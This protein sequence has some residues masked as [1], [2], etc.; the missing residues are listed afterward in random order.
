MDFLFWL[1]VQFIIFL[2]VAFLLYKFGE[3]VAPPLTDVGNKLRSYACGD[4]THYP[5]LSKIEANFHLF[6]IAVFFT[7]VDLGIMM[8]A[9]ISAE[10][11]FNTVLIYFSTIVLTMIIMF[12]KNKS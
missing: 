9:T 12:D 6:D 3:A 1:P 2:M 11:N 10:S 5:E 8:L 4:T 7:I